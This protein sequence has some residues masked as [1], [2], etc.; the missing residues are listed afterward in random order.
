MPLTTASVKRP[1]RSFSAIIE[2]ISLPKF[3]A[4]FFIDALVSDDSKLLGA[5]RKVEQDG[6]A[7]LGGA[8]PE[9][10]ETACRAAGDVITVDITSGDKDADLAGGPAFRLLN[11]LNNCSLVKLAEKIVSSHGRTTIFR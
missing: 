2:A 3:G 1:A 5:R 6:V 7:I 11:G 8:H 9:L 10:L 4:E